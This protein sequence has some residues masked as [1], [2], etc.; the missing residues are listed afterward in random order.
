MS[1]SDFDR[2]PETTFPF[3]SASG[4]FP[5]DGGAKR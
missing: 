2:V 3:Q 4:E 1:A 5:D